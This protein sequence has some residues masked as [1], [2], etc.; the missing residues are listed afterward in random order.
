MT[1]PVTSELIHDLVSRSHSEGIAKLAVECAIVHEERL[2]LLIEPGLDFI[3]DTVQLPQGGVLPGET[4]DDAV[5]RALATVGVSIEEMIGYVGHHDEEDAGEI[6]RVFCFALTV[7]DPDSPCRFSTF[8]HQ[9]AEL[10]DL[11]DLPLPTELSTAR[12][13]AETPV[14][15]KNPPPSLAE[16]LLAGASGGLHTAQAATQLL[17]GHATWLARS[18]FR[19]R[20]VHRHRRDAACEAIA[21]IDWAGA[22]SALDAGEL[23]CSGSEGRMLR[24]AASLADGIP[25]DLGDALIALDSANIELVNQAVLWMS[26]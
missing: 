24:L 7:T 8:S 22:I 20:F 5:G 13:L 10:A 26:R 14:H 11:P 9:W 23:P 18:D 21:V 25:V 4:L 1:L 2:L 16:S 6:T 17:I 15:H 12:L 19:E 3:N